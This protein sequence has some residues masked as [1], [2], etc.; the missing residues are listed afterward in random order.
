MSVIKNV[1]DVTA[2]MIERACGRYLGP[3]LCLDI[4]LRLGTCL[5]ARQMGNEC[6][7]QQCVAK[8]CPHGFGR[9][10]FPPG[11][12]ITTWLSDWPAE[13]LQEAKDKGSLMEAVMWPKA[14]VVYA[15]SPSSCGR[16]VTICDIAVAV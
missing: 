14:F 8:S 4:I 12:V 1:R 15:D 6:F 10:P 2:A 16:F 7:V 11:P 9:F 5:R 13:K 3:A